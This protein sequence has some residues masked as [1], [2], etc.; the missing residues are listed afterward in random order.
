MKAVTFRPIALATTLCVAMASAV[1]AFGPVT[2]AS[3]HREAPLIS[4]DPQADATDLYAFVT[5]DNPDT[6]TIIANYIPFEHPDGAPNFYGFSDDVLYEIHIDNVGDAAKHLSYQFTFTT[7]DANPATFLY[8]TGVVSSLSDPDLSIRQTYTISESVLPIGSIVPT[9]TQIGTGIVPPP[10]IGS[11]SMPDYPALASEGIATLTG[12]GAGIKVFAGPRDDPFWVDLGS[13]FDLLSLRGQLSPIGY[14]GGPTVGIDSVSGFNVHSIV[15]QVPITRLLSSQQDPVIGIWTTASRRSTRVLNPPAAVLTEAPGATG[16]SVHSG[17]LVQV[18]R[19]GMPLTN[20]VVL[21]R[22]LKDTFNGLDPALDFPIYT[23]NAGSTPPFNDPDIIAAGAVLRASVL[24]PELQ[25]LLNGLYGVPN[26]GNNRVDLQEIFLQGMI[27]DKPF[28]VYVGNAATPTLVPAP[29]NV[30]APSKGTDGLGAGIVPAEMLRLNTAPAFR[31]GVSGSLCKS[32]PDYSLGLLGGDV[33]GFPNGRRLQDD[34]TRIELLA[35]AG[36]AFS[37][38]TPGTFNFDGATF[39]P[40]L[41]DG[42]THNDKPFLPAFPYVA[43]PH[44]G[45]EWDHL[46]LVRNHMPLVVQVASGPSAMS[47]GV[48]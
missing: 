10:N 47:S 4:N 9:T 25:R 23:A 27:T 40:I 37:A 35:V 38:L 12:P 36:A 24:D 46:S 8:N 18:S 48:R 1:M 7:T 30:N 22:A 17:P 3:S 13:I 42:T 43:T 14:P 20:E 45:Q 11:K 44:Q 2:N 15:I 5:P 21:P 34:A 41:T 29:V 19:L 39:I 16:L 32:P 31:P 33:C 28:P 6:V 26:P